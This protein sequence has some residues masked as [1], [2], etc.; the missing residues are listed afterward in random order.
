MKINPGWRP[1]G[2]EIRR[3]EHGQP[4]HLEV[5]SFAD[6]L[7]DHEQRASQEQLKQMMEEINR[8]AERL[9]RSMTLR[10]LRQYKLLIK[11]FLEETARRGVGIRDTRGWDRRGRTKRYKL[12]EEIDKH[13]LELADDLISSEQ[14]R[15]EILY[16]I[17][18][19]R[20][21]LINLRF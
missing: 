6:T 15:I 1:L 4:Q 12:L 21:L 17:G 11:R 18:E 5:K 8:Q 14:G 3:V 7:R 2:G 10:D 13:L 19:I 20:G 16:R 9:A